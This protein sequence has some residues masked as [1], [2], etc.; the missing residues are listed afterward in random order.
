MATKKLLWISGSLS[1]NHARSF[2]IRHEKSHEAPPGGGL[3]MTISET[4]HPRLKVTMD[5]YHEVLVA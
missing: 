3:M 4:M 5:Y 1:G 2:I